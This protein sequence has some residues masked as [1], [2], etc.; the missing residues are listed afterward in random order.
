MNKQIIY[1]FGLFLVAMAVAWFGY[2]WFIGFSASLPVPEKIMNAHAKNGATIPWLEYLFLFCT[3]YL[4]Y[5]L[6]SALVT[7]LS[8]R[9]GNPLVVVAAV[10]LSLF[11]VRHISYSFT[12]WLSQFLLTLTLSLVVAIYIIYKN[13][14][15]NA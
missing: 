5:S 6:F 9:V 12:H 2:H 3:F 10:G 15:K 8:S 14:A 1:N 4:P 13:R 11:S 7:G